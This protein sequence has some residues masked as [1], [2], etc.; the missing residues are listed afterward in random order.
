MINLFTLPSLS[1]L[2]KRVHIHAKY[3][4][5]KLSL[6]AIIL[7]LFTDSKPFR[8]G[9]RPILILVKPQRQR[10]L[11]HS[12]PSPPA[13]SGIGVAR[14]VFYRTRCPHFEYEYEK[15]GKT[16]IDNPKH[17]NIATS[18]KRGEGSK[19]RHVWFD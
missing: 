19:R 17:P 10:K 2:E 5:R 18:K 6:L 9:K 3:A 4:D 12:N 1:E 7:G 14:F 8:T 13:Q 15:L 16:S 11:M